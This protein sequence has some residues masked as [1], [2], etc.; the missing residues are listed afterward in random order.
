MAEDSLRRYLSLES[1]KVLARIGTPCCGEV[2]SKVRKFV[3][4]TGER[5]KEKIGK[6]R[7]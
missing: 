2:L 4:G 5:G 6:S 3:E 7:G 1:A